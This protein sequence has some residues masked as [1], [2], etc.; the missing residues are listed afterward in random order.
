VDNSRAIRVQADL[1]AISTQLGLYNSFTDTYPTTEQGLR[2]LV[3]HPTTD[4]LPRRWYQL[5]RELPKDP[6]GHEYIYKYP[7]AAGAD[8]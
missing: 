3:E 8:S 1:A 6:W 4:P 7:G 5:F 2:V